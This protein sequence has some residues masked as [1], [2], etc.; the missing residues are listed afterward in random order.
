VWD[1]AAARWARP[2]HILCDSQT[3][4]IGWDLTDPA[5]AGRTEAELRARDRAEYAA[6]RRPGARWRYLGVCYA[7][8]LLG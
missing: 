4:N 5:N 6:P 7:D 2:A 3:G 8:R 1:E